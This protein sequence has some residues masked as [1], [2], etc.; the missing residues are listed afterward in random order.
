MKQDNE[1]LF[2]AIFGERGREMAAEAAAIDPELASLIEEIPLERI[3]ARP[4]LPLRDK[5]LITL[6]SQI[7]L[8]RWDQVELHMRS[9]L[10]VGGSP[11]ELREICYHLSVYCG[12]PVMVRAVRIAHE[13][14]RETTQR[15]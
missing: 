4:K 10:H 12:F 7:A 13:L 8:E 11:G 14:T 3:W 9:F 6:A 5:S 15:G 1:E 2:C